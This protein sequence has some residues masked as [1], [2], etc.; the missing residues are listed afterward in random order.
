VARTL[1]D[2]ADRDEP[3]SLDDVHAALVLRGDVFP[4]MDVAS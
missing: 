4:A 1:A 3:V 2:L